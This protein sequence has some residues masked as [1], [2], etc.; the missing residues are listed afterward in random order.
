MSISR[1][2]N[3]AKPQEVMRVM[4]ACYKSLDVCTFNMADFGL[5]IQNHIVFLRQCLLV[6]RRPNEGLLEQAGLLAFPES[7]S[8]VKLFASQLRK[9]VQNCRQKKRQDHQWSQ[10]DS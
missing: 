2:K 4:R 6:T 8:T 7:P 3:E 1:V 5:V 10:T 9:A